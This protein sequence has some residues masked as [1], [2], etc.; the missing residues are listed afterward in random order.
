VP[1]TEP[2][3]HERHDRPA[4]L[5]VRPRRSDPAVQCVGAPTAGQNGILER[6]GT[7]SGATGMRR[8]L[9]GIDAGRTPEA[10]DHGDRGATAQNACLRHERHV[11]KRRGAGCQRRIA[12]ATAAVESERSTDASI[13]AQAGLAKPTSGTSMATRHGY[14]GRMV[15]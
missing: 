1:R 4:L 2:F 15:R 8:E 7:N 9:R 13:R 12:A 11:E 5:Q 14:R 3:G 10:H 6:A